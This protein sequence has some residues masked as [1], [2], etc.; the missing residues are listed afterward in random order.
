MAISNTMHDAITHKTFAP[1]HHVASCTNVGINA[2]YLKTGKYKGIKKLSRWP[3]IKSFGFT[4]QAQ[5]LVTTAIDMV[6]GAH[7]FI[8]E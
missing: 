1:I 2:T 8:I 6:T 4:G 5:R 7:A 3:T